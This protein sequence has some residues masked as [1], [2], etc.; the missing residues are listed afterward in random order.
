MAPSLEDLKV[1]LVDRSVQTGS[2]T[3]ASGVTS[4]FYIDARRTTMSADG[5]RLVGSLGLEA[6]R[7]AG[8]EAGLVGG[9]TMGADPVAYAI[10]LASLDRPPRIDAF[11]VRKDAK[12]H[13]MGRRIEGCFESN[14]PVVIVEDVLTSGQ[15]AL[16][17]IETVRDAGGIISGV[18]AI[19][20]RE[21]GGRER[22]EELGLSLRALLTA[23][24]LGL[25][26]TSH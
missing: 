2:F 20:D 4:S 12:E 21:Q 11:S 14:R 7:L 23:T 10:A 25:A 18:L 6:I 3:L 19:V 22:I 26:A 17:A 13:G 1:L 16:T 8:W 24:D 5:L 9:L 15:S